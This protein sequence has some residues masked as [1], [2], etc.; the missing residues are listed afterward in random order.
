MPN[1]LR[2]YGL[3]T[4]SHIRIFSRNAMIRRLG[5][6]SSAKRPISGCAFPGAEPAA[7]PLTWGNC[8]VWDC[9]RRRVISVAYLEARGRLHCTCTCRS[10]STMTHF[11]VNVW[12]RSRSPMRSWTTGNRGPRF[13]L[14]HPKKTVVCPLIIRGRRHETSSERWMREIRTS[15]ATSG[16]WRRD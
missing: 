6:P 16:G 9:W 7:P 13:S 5:F 12:S 2:K 15:S 14:P 4:R 11:W 1:D 3:G 10:G 8:A